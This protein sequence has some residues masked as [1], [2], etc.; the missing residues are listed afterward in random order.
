MRCSSK[1]RKLM[2]TTIRVRFEKNIYINKKKCSV[3][4]RTIADDILNNPPYIVSIFIYTHP[5][6][7][8]HFKAVPLDIVTTS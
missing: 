3:K 1:L 4:V 7:Y 6:I 2:Y 5:N 8:L